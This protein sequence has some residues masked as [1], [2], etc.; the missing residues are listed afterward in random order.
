MFVS[1]SRPTNQ[2]L[3]QPCDKIPDNPRRQLCA[4]HWQ[5]WKKGFPE[6][7]GISILCSVDKCENQTAKTWKLCYQHWSQKA[8]WSKTSRNPEHHRGWNIQPE[9]QGDIPENP[10]TAALKK[11]RRNLE[12]HWNICARHETNTIQYLITPLLNSLG[13]DEYDPQQVIKEYKMNPRSPYPRSEAVDIALIQ[14][15]CPE[16]L[17]EVKRIDREYSPEHR[18]QLERYASYLKSGKAVLTNG[19]HWQIHEIN[20]RKIRHLLTIDITAGSLNETA[21]KLEAELGKKHRLEAGTTSHHSENSRKPLGSPPS[22]A[23]RNS[24]PPKDFWQQTGEFLRDMLNPKENSRKPDIPLANPIIRE[25]YL[26]T[27]SEIKKMIHQ[28]NLKG[29]N[30]EISEREIETLAVSQ[31]TDIKHMIRTTALSRSTINLHGE[32]ILRIVREAKYRVSNPRY[33][34]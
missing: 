10:V 12:T 25:R 19:R 8:G 17:I 16:I 14:N 3:E 32:N 29:A 7:Q 9:E 13:W 26:A 1:T 31:P 15:G 18:M 22:V 5:E 33:R 11:T 21:G 24:P 2:C 34:P 20:M 28:Y 6:R 30:P 23:P 4:H 27:K